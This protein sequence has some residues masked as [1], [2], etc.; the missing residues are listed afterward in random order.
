MRK[1]ITNIRRDTIHALMSW[2][3]PG[4][5]RELE[6][7]IERAVILSQGNT[8]NAPLAELAS[9]KVRVAPVLTVRDSERIAIITALKAAKGKI[10]GTDGAAARLCLKRTPPLNKMRKLGIAPNEYRG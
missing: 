8:L 10:S 7:F 1:S 3:W 9:P 2:D 6:N 5:I 4:N